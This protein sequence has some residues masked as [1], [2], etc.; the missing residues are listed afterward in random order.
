MD[1]PLSVQF[2]QMLIM[3]VGCLYVH[4]FECLAF[5]LCAFFTRMVISNL[6]FEVNNIISPIAYFPLTEILLH[7]Y[8]E[9]YITY[10]CKCQSGK[11]LEI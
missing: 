11:F 3:P 2:K 7:L 9:L 1:E 5:C 8:M 4:P 6:V 10:A